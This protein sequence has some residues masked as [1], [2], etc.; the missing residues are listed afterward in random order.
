[1]IPQQSGYI[2]YSIDNVGTA[3]EEL[4]PGPVRLLGAANNLSVN[5]LLDIPCGHK[6]AL[7]KISAGEPILKYGA[8]IG[9]AT[10]DIAQG[11]HVHLHNMKS[12]FDERSGTLDVES[13]VPTDVEYRL[14]FSGEED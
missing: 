12:N 3:L 2:V 4:T 11:D 14:H 13:A 7:K 5:A 1:M 8:C 10:S 6:F 9:T